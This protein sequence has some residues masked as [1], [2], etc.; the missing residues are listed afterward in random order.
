[1]SVP[2]QLG[3]THRDGIAAAIF[4]LL[5]RGA[6]Q[7]PETAAGARGKVVVRFSEP[8]APVRIS[9][10]SRR[11]VVADGDLRSPDVIIE[12]RLPDVINLAMAPLWRGVPKPTDRRG[13]A[14][15]R[16]VARRRVRLR[17]DRA[18][19]RGLLSLLAL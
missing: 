19:A 10:G 6:A 13:R 17:G 2:V 1:M 12:G 9:F 3:R 16:H 7:R 11:I 15:I 8:Y 5:E 14:A 18:L 4:A